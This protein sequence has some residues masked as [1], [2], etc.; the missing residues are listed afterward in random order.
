MQPVLK[1]AA[2]GQQ[3]NDTNGYATVTKQFFFLILW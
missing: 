3:N 2:L 1:P